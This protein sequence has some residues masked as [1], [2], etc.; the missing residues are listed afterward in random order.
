MCIRDS[1]NRSYVWERDA[2][3]HSV[4]GEVGPFWILTF[5]GFVF[6]TIVVWLAGFISEETVFL[7]AAQMAAF[8][9][10]WLVK[11]AVLEKYLW[12]DEAEAPAERV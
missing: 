7:L 1:L 6:S 3:N 9:A 5:V 12:P 8:G 11:F 4:S 2:G 10:L